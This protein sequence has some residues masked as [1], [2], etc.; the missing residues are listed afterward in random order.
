[1][2]NQVKQPP[3]FSAFPWFPNQHFP[4]TSVRRLVAVH[5]FH[6]IRFLDQE[7]QRDTGSFPGSSRFLNAA[8]SHTPEGHSVLLY[9]RG[10]NVSGLFSLFGL[11][12]NTDCAEVYVFRLPS[13][14]PSKP[15]L[16][17]P[18]LKCYKNPNPFKSV[19]F[20]G[21]PLILLPGFLMAFFLFVRSPQWDWGFHRLTIPFE[22]C[23]VFLFFPSS[24][25]TLGEFFSSPTRSHL[26]EMFP[27]IRSLSSLKALLPFFPLKFS[28]YP[29]PS[30]TFFLSFFC[31]RGVVSF[32]PF[33]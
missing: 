15:P 11:S 33:R 13:G 16:L 7:T 22:W 6:F 3:V 25:V 28:T 8:G 9:Q 27:S 1:L 21:N 5:T 12:G 26:P 30:H 17:P 32:G 31:L 18:P 24:H 2:S 10:P 20:L 29:I 14:F 19:V 23:V 4:C